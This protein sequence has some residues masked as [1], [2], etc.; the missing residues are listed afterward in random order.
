M[1]SV[2]KQ[3]RNHH[4]S[5]RCTGVG[6]IVILTKLYAALLQAVDVRNVFLQKLAPRFD[7]VWEY[8]RV[9]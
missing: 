2:Y 8:S 9:P 6:S 7:V 1:P 3:P 5:R 4:T